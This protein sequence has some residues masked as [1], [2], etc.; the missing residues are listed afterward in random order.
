MKIGSDEDLDSCN[1]RTHFFAQIEK[2]VM[3]Q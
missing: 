3:L 1:S 2:V